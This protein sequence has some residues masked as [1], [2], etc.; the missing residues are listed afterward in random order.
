MS[1]IVKSTVALPKNLG[2]Q[3]VVEGVETKDVLDLLQSYEC[4]IAQGYFFAKPMKSSD[5]AVWF[6]ECHRKH[7]A[8]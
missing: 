8:K 4:D 6:E 3:V 5:L 1:E 2:Y 7:D